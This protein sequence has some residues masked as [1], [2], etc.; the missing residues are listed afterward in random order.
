VLH[1]SFDL[2]EV[3]DKVA[4]TSYREGEINK[5]TRALE[6]VKG[7]VSAAICATPQLSLVIVA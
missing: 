3:F 6:V 1:V 7:I 4:S 2:D 5:V